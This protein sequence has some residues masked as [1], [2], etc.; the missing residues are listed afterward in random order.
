MGKEM[1]VIWLTNVLFPQVCRHLGLP[2]PVLGGWMFG[3]YN[4]LR[5]YCP[6]IH[7]YIVAP[8]PE[9][10]FQKVA[11]EGHTFYAYPA[12]LPA[13]ALSGWLQEVCA[14]ISP[15]VVHI[16]GSELAHAS[17]FVRSCGSARVL[18]SVQGLMHVCASYYWAGIDPHLLRRYRTLRDVL[19][20]DTVER[21]HRVFCRRGEA[22]KW[23]ISNVHYLAG[24]TLWDRAHCWSLNPSMHYF[25]CEEALR[26]AFYRHQWSLQSCSRYTIFVSQVGYPIKG[27]HQLLKALPLIA[28]HYPDVQVRIVGD[29]LSE[30]P[31]FKRTTYWNYLFT[32]YL[33]RP[34]ISSRCHFLGRLTEEEMVR[35]Y[36][37]AHVFVCPS[38]IENSSNSVCEAQL[39]GTPVVAAQ[40]G[41]MDN[42]IESGHSGL[43]YR[44]EETEMLAYAVCRLFA[45]DNLAITLSEGA[46]RVASHRHDRRQIALSLHSLYTHIAAQAEEVKNN[47]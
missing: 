39:L 6:D 12:N 47:E 38:A 41:G 17:L 19:R 26:D 21:Q 16:H 7:L 32:E 27:L 8:G 23:L 18:L 4:A 35:Q 34:E 25:P 14:E 22:E 42:L 44:F 37:S 33:S 40:V 1:K 24:R 45:D 36:L 2:E 11:L 43:L 30:K 13:G 28:C 20:R 31:W 10:G 5:S 3:Y 29:N 9:N 15:D 46:R